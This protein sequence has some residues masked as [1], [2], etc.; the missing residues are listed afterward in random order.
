VVC[1]KGYESRDTDKINLFEQ[2]IDRYCPS[3]FSIMA[4]LTGSLDEKD[5]ETMTVNVFFRSVEEQ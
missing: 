3:V 4:R 2:F 5:L 1:T